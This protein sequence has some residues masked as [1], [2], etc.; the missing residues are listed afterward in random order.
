MEKPEDHKKIEGVDQRTARSRVSALITAKSIMSSPVRT[1]LSSVSVEEAQSALQRHGHTSLCVVNE[2]GTLLGII[3]RRD[4]DISRRHGLGHLPITGFMSNQIKSVGSTAPV[5]QMQKMMVT[6][7][8]GRLPVLEAG[9]LVGIVT[10]TDLL[11]GL[12]QAYQYPTCKNQT[13]NQSGEQSDEPSNEPGSPLGPPLCPPTAHTLHQ[14][15][16]SRLSAIWPALMLIADIADQKGWALYLVGGAVRDLLLS[17]V[18]GAN[19][20]FRPLTDIDLVVDGAEEGAGI[21]LA[22]AVQARYPS[23][24]MQIYGQFQ[25]AALTWY[26]GSNTASNTQT[27]GN[28]EPLLLDIA[29]AR[30][31]FYP[32]PAANPE[33]EASTIHQDLYRRDFTINAM[34]IRLNR[35]L[36]ETLPGQLLDFFGGWLDL[37]QRHVRVIHP[38]SFIED[39][40][41]IFRA[42]RFALRLG[43]SIN[44]QTEQFIRCA[45]SSGIYEQMRTS[46]DKTPALQARLGAELKY[47]LSTV[48]WEAALAEIS[49]LGA[50]ACLH[51]SLE[52]TPALWRQLRRMN[53]WLNKFDNKFDGKYLGDVPPQWLMLLE[54][55]VAQLSPPFRERTAANLALSA[56]SQHRLK[57]LHIWEADLARQMPKADRPSKI[58]TL[59]KQ[60]GQAELL[61][62]SDRHPHTLG[63]QIWQYIVQISHQPPLIN[64]A[65]L[66]RLG[67][68][69]GPLFK[70]ILSDVHMLTLDGELPKAQSVEDYVLAHYAQ[71]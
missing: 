61:L 5:A 56:Q 11:R 64:G 42:V 55:I 6:Y 19:K 10:R 32:Y 15:L 1:V 52:M 33:V 60:Y 63:P 39:P 71:Q 50:L 29:T 14:Q 41:R 36:E 54:L 21:A 58:Y 46:A 59:L 53:R 34:A 20:Q 23:V 26:P 57:S 4:I 35:K 27:S 24:T 40:T 67:Y 7:D 66:K 69:P 25:T 13:E 31:E 47:M 48:Y 22:K 17:L 49:R 38:N 70:E 8:L 2:Q 28:T 43:F 65:T 44:D 12:H 51:R 18:P 3:S 30:T 37:Q 68:S 9:K 16:K 45:I 62:M